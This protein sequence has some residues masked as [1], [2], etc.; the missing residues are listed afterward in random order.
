M[1][2]KK[3]KQILNYIY[4]HNSITIKQCSK[5]IFTGNRCAYDQSRKQLRRLYKE[6]AIAR[7]RASMTDEV[8]YY[9]STRLGVHEL[10]LLNVYA[11]LIGKGAKVETFHKKY[12]IYTNNKKYREIDALIELTYNDYFIPLIVEID[13]SHNTSIDKLEEIYQSNHFQNKYREIDDNIF[14]LIVICRP[15]VEKSLS[16]DNELQILYTDFDLKNLDEVLD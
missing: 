15:V 8:V 3:D 14:P 16:N 13:Y 6:K 4:E 11:E 2:S 1:L 10:Q 9:I 12:R 5:V 7:Y